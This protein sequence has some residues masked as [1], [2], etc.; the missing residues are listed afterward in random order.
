[1]NSGGCTW[2]NNNKTNK[3]T[4]IAKRGEVSDFFYLNT[5]PRT[6]PPVE[7]VNVITEDLKQEIVKKKLVVQ[8]WT[9]S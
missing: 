6:P 4:I 9:N 8:Y 2:Y 5:K 7:P 1:M 3:F